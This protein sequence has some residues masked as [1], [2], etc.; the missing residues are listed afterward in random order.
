MIVDFT[1]LLQGTHQFT[2][3][4]TPAWWQSKIS[5]YQVM[6][7]EKPVIANVMVR[8]DQTGYV[9]QG[10][11]SGSVNVEC[12]RCLELFDYTL[13]P[14]FSLHVSFA[15]PS[16]VENTD[17]ELVEKDFTVAGGDEGEVDLQELVMEQI[18]L[19]LPMRL[20][21][22]EDCLGLCS[23]CGA[24]LNRKKCDCRK[25]T[26][27]SAFLKLKALEFHKE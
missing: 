25:H 27:H 4:L 14:D 10:S 11:V 2:V 24:N 6:G 5:D 8:K 20:L 26:G 12:G 7:L 22:R 23:E 15:S 17:V 18:F 3:T 1:A 9:I 19:S 16:C 13:K 21:C